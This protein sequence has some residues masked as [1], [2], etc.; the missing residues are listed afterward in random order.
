MHTLIRAALQYRAIVLMGMAL[1]ITFGIYSLHQLPID[2][3]PDI[4]PNQVVV[5]ARAPSLS[6]VEV[7]QF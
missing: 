6:P 3:V 2:A 1:A 7:E 4:T 5:L